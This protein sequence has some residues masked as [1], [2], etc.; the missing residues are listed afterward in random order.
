VEKS[1]ITKPVVQVAFV[2]VPAS[3]EGVHGVPLGGWPQVKAASGRTVV[4]VVELVGAVVLTG[5]VVVVGAT[6]DVVG[7]L[8]VVVV[9]PAQVPSVAQASNWEK[10]PRETPQALPFRHFAV[11]PTIDDLTLPFFF[12]T[13]QTAAFGLPQI[14][15]L[16]HF[17]MSLRHA[18]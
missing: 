15:A 6:V 4:D 18:F 10:K 16:S 5:V 8:V 3:S 9:G 14:E 13:Q 11:L 2:V 17:M 12:R 7:G 1:V